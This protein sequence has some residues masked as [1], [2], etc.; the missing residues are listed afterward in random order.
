M[1]DEEEFFER[2]VRVS[3][4]SRC[5]SLRVGGP[6][7]EDIEH[8]GVRPWFGNFRHISSSLLIAFAT[9]TLSSRPPQGPPVAA[10]L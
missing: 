9:Y 1:E 10:M 2:I 8:G 7:V 6:L 4:G 3:G 5:Y